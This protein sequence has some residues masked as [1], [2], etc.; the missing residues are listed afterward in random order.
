MKELS[1]EEKAQA[2]ESIFERL[3]EMYNNNKANVAARL[4]YEKYFP[5]LKESEDEKIREAAI[6]FVRQNNS[7]NYRLGISKE[8]QVGQMLLS[9]K[10]K[11][12]KKQLICLK[13]QISKS[14]SFHYKS[15]FYTVI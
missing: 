4:K 7:F 9:E 2:Y 6:E 5:E 1:I 13:K 14:L 8:L 3:K 12:Q 11:N 15:L 10:L